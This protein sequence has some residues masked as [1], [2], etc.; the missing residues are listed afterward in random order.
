MYDCH[1]NIEAEEMEW[2]KIGVGI[3][4]AGCGGTDFVPIFHLP[5]ITCH[6]IAFLP[7]FRCFGKPER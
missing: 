7:R 1:A 3:G 4:D 2:I 5:L 6:Y